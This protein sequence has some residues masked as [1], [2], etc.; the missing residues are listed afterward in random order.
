MKKVMIPV[1][2]AMATTLTV[3]G[4]AMAGGKNDPKTKVDTAVTL[5][6]TSDPYDPYD[7]YYEQS[8]TFAGTVTGSGGDETQNSKCEK[9]RTILIKNAADPK[10]VVGY[11]TTNAAGQFNVHT[12][13]NYIEAGDYFAKAQ[14]KR[15]VKAKIKCRGGKSNTVS[16]PGGGGESGN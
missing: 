5:A 13:G 10:I 6:F 8:G 12:P 3:G 16:V 4:I 1:V 14:K 11:D 9:R 7:P 2:A 15:K